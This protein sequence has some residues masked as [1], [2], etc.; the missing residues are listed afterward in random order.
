MSTK[1][2]TFKT[3]ISQIPSGLDNKE[4]SD[5]RVERDRNNHQWR[6]KILLIVDFCLSSF[7][8]RFLSI[9]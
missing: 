3:N 9:I 8:S 5:K 6:L 7:K 4:V 1:V 2:Q